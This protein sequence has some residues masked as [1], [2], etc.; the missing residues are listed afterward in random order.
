MTTKKRTPHYRA[1]KQQSYRRRKTKE[2]AQ[3][4]QHSR[5]QG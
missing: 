3:T 5:Q 2:A 1:Q 4:E